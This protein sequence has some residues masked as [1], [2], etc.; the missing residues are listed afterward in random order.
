[1]FLFGSLIHSQCPGECLANIK[2]SKYI[3][4]ETLN[5]GVANELFC[6]LDSSAG[7][8]NLRELLMVTVD[9]EM[10]DIVCGFETTF[11]DLLMYTVFW[12]WRK[13]DD[14]WTLFYIS[15]ACV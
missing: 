12:T 2:C 11:S 6:P 10:V 13:I 4:A 9:K 8:F 3:F 7:E 5:K 14:V 15:D 1:M